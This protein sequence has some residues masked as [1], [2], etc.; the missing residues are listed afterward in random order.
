MRQE[1]FTAGGKPGLAGV[2]T[3]WKVGG[4]HKAEDVHDALHGQ[5]VAGGPFVLHAVFPLQSFF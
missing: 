4:S 1:R 3:G 5:N 2:Q